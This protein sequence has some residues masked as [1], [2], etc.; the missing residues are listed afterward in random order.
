MSNE[1]GARVKNHDARIL[2]ALVQKK[3]KQETQ[4][5]LA[6][7]ANIIWKMAEEQ[8]IV[9]NLNIFLDEYRHK[10]IIFSCMNLP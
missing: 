3:E 7:K 2:D 1:N 6:N 10:N 8:V 5:S 9:F 4:D